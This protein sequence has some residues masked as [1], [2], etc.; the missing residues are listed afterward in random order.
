MLQLEDAEYSS[1]AAI[2]AKKT[3]ELELADLQ[4]QID[5]LFKTKQEVRNH[6]MESRGI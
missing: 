2:R 1:Q 3:M 5:E 4:Q 6:A